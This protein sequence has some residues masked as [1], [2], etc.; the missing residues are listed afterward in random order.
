MNLVTRFMPSG[1]E[2]DHAARVCNRAT[3]EV[4]DAFDWRET[5]VTLPPFYL[6]PGAQDHGSPA[7]AVPS[8]FQGLRRAY[9][10][11]LSGGAVTPTERELTIVRYLEI[12]ETKAWPKNI[13]YEPA[14]AAFRIFPR[15]PDNMGPPFYL[16]TG[17]YKKDPTKLTAS[18][19]ATT[20]L[21][22]GDDSAFD[23]WFE[24]LKWSAMAFSGSPQAGS[25]SVQGQQVQKNGQAAV[26]QDYILRLA[27][28]EGFELGNITIAPAEGIYRGNTWGGNR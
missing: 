22:L 17:T 9:I 13:S 25:F 18:T 11:D 10:R 2:A 14:A 26:A 24:L 27:A 3:N 12:T 20:L 23:T 1:W 4:W 16:V 21:P 5:I 15:V 6:I 8:D 28:K 7:V 19:Y